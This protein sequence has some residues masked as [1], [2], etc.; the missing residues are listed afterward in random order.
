MLRL[1]MGRRRSKLVGGFLWFILGFFRFRY[2][3]IGFGVWRLM[4]GVNTAR[5]AGIREACLWAW[6]FAEARI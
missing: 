3:L 5:T 4:R 6:C 1:W 2:D